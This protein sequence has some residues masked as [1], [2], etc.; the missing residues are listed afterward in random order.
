MSNIF[1]A[2]VYLDIQYELSFILVSTEAQIIKYFGVQSAALFAT[3]T[4]LCFEL[5]KRLKLM[6][7]Y[8]HVTCVFVVLAHHN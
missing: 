5:Q 8:L 3:F 4:K 7:R 2:L 6:L 1:E